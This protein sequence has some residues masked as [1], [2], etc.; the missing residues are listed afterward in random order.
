MSEVPLYDPLEARN[1]TF[2]KRLAGD[3]GTNSG[4]EAGTYLRLIEF[5]YH[6]TLGW[7]V[8]K[9]KKK[10]EAQTSPIS[11][12]VAPASTHRNDSSDLTGPHG[13]G[14][15]ADAVDAPNAARGR[16]CACRSVAK[17]RIWL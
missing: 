10:I 11:S 16:P 9:K 12:R 6:S 1:G 14:G 17:A 13:R 3:R 4:S 7:R 5:V 8:I 2:V 15:L